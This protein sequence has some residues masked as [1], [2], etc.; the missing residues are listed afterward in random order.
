MAN[1]FEASKEQRDAITAIV[2]EDSAVFF[3]NAGSALAEMVNR[4]IEL[5]VHDHVTGPVPSNLAHG[6]PQSPVE[7]LHEDGRITFL[8][9]G[10]DVA[11]QLS[12]Q[13]QRCLV[14]NIEKI[15]LIPHAYAT[16]NEISSLQDD[17]D[18]NVVEVNGR[19]YVKTSA[20]SASIEVLRR[21]L[22][23]MIGCYSVG[24]LLTRDFPEGSPCSAIVSVFDGEGW[25]LV[26]SPLGVRGGAIDNRHIN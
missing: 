17:F 20:G 1:Y 11:L 10:R 25:A 3:Q 7:D 18:G 15:L 14:E 21:A 5:M 4:P 8:S 6:L 23:S 26:G 12:T 24:W 19:V 13:L 2:L 16:I 22:S 9:G